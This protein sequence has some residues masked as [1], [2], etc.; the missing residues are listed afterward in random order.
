MA[1]PKD[2]D[3]IVVGAGM[4]GII[5]AAR[6]AEKGVNPKTGERLRIALIEAGPLMFKEK[7]RPGYGAA[8]HR[9]LVPEI[10]WEEFR[11]VD[12]WPWPFGLKIVGGCSVHWG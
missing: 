5:V 9:Q 3:L 1:N 12:Q 11:F 10:V 8:G 7:M 6:V 4:A 2:Y